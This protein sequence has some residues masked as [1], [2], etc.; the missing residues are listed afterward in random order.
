MVGGMFLYGCD[1]HSSY[2]EQPIQIS[3]NSPPTI[4]ICNECVTRMHRMGVLMSERGP[5]DYHGPR[6]CVV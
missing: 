2:G 6:V 3:Q 1:H 5:Y 4:A